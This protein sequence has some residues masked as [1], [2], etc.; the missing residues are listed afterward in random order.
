VKHLKTVEH[1]N[2]EKLRV[3]VE[4]H[5]ST[6]D[7]LQLVDIKKKCEQFFDKK[8]KI[9]TKVSGRMRSSSLMVKSEKLSVKTRKES[10]SLYGSTACRR[11]SLP[12]KFCKTLNYNLQKLLCINSV[13]YIFGSVYLCAAGEIFQRNFMLSAKPD[14]MRLSKIFTKLYEIGVKTY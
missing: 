1:K 8:P 10:R 7:T 5:F 14:C 11:S 4:S 9:W 6:S 2:F 3:W 13:K 12:T